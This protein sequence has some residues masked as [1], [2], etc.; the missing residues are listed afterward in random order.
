MNQNTSYYMMNPLAMISKIFA[1]GSMEVLKP[2]SITPVDRRQVYA[3]LEAY[4]HNTVYNREI[5]RGSLDYV[6]RELGEAAARDLAGLFNPIERGTELYAQNVFA[7]NFGDEIVIAD[8]VGPKNKPRP[9]NAEIVEPLERIWDWSNFNFGEKERYPR[10]GSLLGTVGIRVVARVG[11]DFPRDNPEER[12]VY[13]QFEHPSIIE[14]YVKNQQQEVTQILTIHHEL[15]GDIDLTNPQ[16]GRDVNVYKTLMTEAKFQTLKNDQPYNEV[17][18]DIDN[19]FVTTP[20][21]LGKVP[22]VLAFHRKLEGAWGAWWFIGSENPIDRLNSIV[23]HINRQI[24]RHVKVKWL[25]TSKGNP[26]REFNFSDTSVLFVKLLPEQTGNDTQIKPLVSDLNLEDAITQA[27]FMLGELRDR[28]PELKAIDGNFLS[29]TTGQTIAQ[30]RIPAIDRL[31]VARANYEAG[32]IKA[33]KLALA[34]GILLGIW[35]LGTGKGDM[36][37]VTRAIKEKK[38]DHKFNERAY[39]TIT[40]SERLQNQL[41]ELQIESERKTSGVLGPNGDNRIAT[42]QQPSD[43]RGSIG[44]IAGSNQGS[45]IIVP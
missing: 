44:Q 19:E 42:G 28:M 32:L 36:E 31:K 35:D 15:E 3:L 16:V 37:A 39:L 45:R 1:P 8:T 18:D 11:K 4:Y 34:Y 24:I 7:G 12:I 25:V 6:N 41:L 26:P 17:I 23:A 2:S 30:L 13:I 9:V 10:L 43:G 38:L 27:K 33:Q 22:Y 29:N 14:D 21:T 40:E 20:N 5:F